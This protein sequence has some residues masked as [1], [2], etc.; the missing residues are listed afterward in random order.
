MDSAPEEAAKSIHIF[1]AFKEE[2]RYFDDG[3]FTF[4]STEQVN[5]FLRQTS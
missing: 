1:N 5:L 3:F 2:N 4:T